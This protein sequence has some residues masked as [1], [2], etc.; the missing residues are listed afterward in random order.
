MNEFKLFYGV[1]VFFIIDIILF[2]K[3]IAVKTL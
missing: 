3:Y 2:F 1:F